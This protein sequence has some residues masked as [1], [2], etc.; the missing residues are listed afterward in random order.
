MDKPA[1]ARNMID[2]EVDVSLAAEWVIAVGALKED[3]A[4]EKGVRVFV[5]DLGLGKSVWRGVSLVG[6]AGKK[7]KGDLG[8]NWNGKWAVEVEGTI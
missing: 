7:R 2:D 5:V 3:M 1:V 4:V 6:T 8:I